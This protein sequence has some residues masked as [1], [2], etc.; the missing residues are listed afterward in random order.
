VD[1]LIFPEKRGWP[2]GGAV[3][4]P[5]TND[6]S[7]PLM[8]LRRPQ[9][10][11]AGTLIRF[12]TR[13]SGMR[14]MRSRSDAG[15]WIPATAWR[16]SEGVI[17]G[18]AEGA[19]RANRSSWCFSDNVAFQW[20]ESQQNGVRTRGVRDE[21][22]LLAFLGKSESDA[23]YGITVT[24]RHGGSFIA[25]ARTSSSAR[26]DFLFERRERNQSRV[27]AR[28]AIRMDAG[29]PGVYTRFKVHGVF[30]AARTVCLL[31]RRRLGNSSAESCRSGS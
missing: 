20:M 11:Y 23:A 17:P 4:I 26:R 25:Y 18:R 6:V 29:H 12:E 13:I 15:W 30:T 8:K 16:C 9:A 1:I 10:A 21:K 14:A 31:A 3:L 7:H 2:I 28:N 27:L 24:V 22:Y 5:H 19:R